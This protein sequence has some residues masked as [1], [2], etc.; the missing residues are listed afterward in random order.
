MDP[1]M[2]GPGHRLAQVSGVLVAD[3]AGLAV[4]DYTKT[5]CLTST[6]SPQIK[7]HRS[8]Q[9]PEPET[10]VIRFIREKRLSWFTVNWNLCRSGVIEER[11]VTSCRQPIAASC[12]EGLSRSC[13][14]RSIGPNI[15]VE[16][17]EA[18]Q[19]HPAPA[20]VLAPGT[21]PHDD[22]HFYNVVDEPPG[23]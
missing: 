10:S 2:R 14:S 6:S 15:Q 1:I 22:P 5:P 8:V 11:G 4:G 17:S 20:P 9:F 23:S 19:L 7:P 16:K 12:R 13:Q 3:R 21:A 18:E